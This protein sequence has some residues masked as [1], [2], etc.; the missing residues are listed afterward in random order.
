MNDWRISQWLRHP[1]RCA[2]ACALLLTWMQPVG[3]ATRQPGSG[4]TGGT[5]GVVA[6]GLEG[7]V[8]ASTDGEDWRR[9]DFADELG[10]GMTIRTGAG[11][12]VD[13]RQATGS[14]VRLEEHGRMR[15]GTLGWEGNPARPLVV[16]EVDL[17]AGSLVGV[18]RGVRG[19]SRHVVRFDGGV[20]STQGADYQV[21]SGGRVAVVRGRME[22]RVGET[23]AVVEEGAVFEAGGLSVRRL[24]TREE[25]LPWEALHSVSR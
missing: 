24:G 12:H 4:A 5:G 15:L 25:G 14:A 20:A 21:T 16:L 23:T 8:E 2:L 1:A 6:R 18:L 19:G 17:E 10:S 11:S 13:A 22:V 9:V 3:C 7:T